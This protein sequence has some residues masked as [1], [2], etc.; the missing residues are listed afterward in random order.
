LKQIKT[1]QNKTWWISF[2]IAGRQAVGFN[3]VLVLFFIS[4]PDKVRH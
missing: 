1:K 4:D 3:S 2:K